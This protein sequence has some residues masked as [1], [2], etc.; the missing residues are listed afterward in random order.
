MYQAICVVLYIDG[1]GRV[2]SQHN[3]GENVPGDASVHCQP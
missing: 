2:E 3:A 1:D